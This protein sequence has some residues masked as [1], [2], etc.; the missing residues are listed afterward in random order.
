MAA[1]RLV[2]LLIFVST[3]IRLW[4][5]AA[6]GLGY[7]ES[8]M[9][10]NAREFALSYVDHPP[11]HVW[12]A[13]LAMRLFDSEAPFV[14]RLPFVLLFAGST[15]LM[16][17]LAGR[18]FG[19]RAGLWAATALTLTPIFSVAFGTFVLPDGPAIFFLLAAALFLARILFHQPPPERPLLWWGVVGLCT[20]L[21]LLSKF[22]AAFFPLAVLAYLITADRWR[23]ATLGPWFA[24]VVALVVFSPAIIWNAQHGW[25][26]IAFQAERV[27]GS[28][29][30]LDTF[31]AQVGG[32]LAYLSPWLAVPYAI[33]LW[34]AFARGPAEP[35]G[36]LLALAA[37]GPIALFTLLTLHTGGL[38]HW[39]MPGWLFAIPLFGRGAAALSP[40]FA[41]AYIAVAAAIFAIVFGAFGVQ[42]L[43]GGLIPA[44]IIAASAAAD[45]TAD[46][47]D[48]TELKPALAGHDLIAAPHWTIAAKASY[49]A[50]PSVTTLC[51]CR[52]PQQFAFRADPNAWAGHDALVILPSGDASALADTAAYFDVLEPLGSVA[53]TR[54][55]VTLLTLD[56]K[57]GKSLHFPAK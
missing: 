45:P 14:V 26:G 1:G 25:I 53:I 50:G 37:I 2:L 5:A 19:E 57:L 27:G 41:R 28:G 22:N 4:L 40:R 30:R 55:G 8:Y 39:T 38:P 47:V 32:E 17:Q 44:S 3:A 46:L 56:L 36:W 31:A 51:L 12:I 49:A 24:A 16:F 35:R 42:A 13:G 20:G 52:S 18:M 54:N 29:L 33:A 34:Q 10:G 23:L 43:R 6:T 48:W 7:D 21:A 15:W 9:V 11:L